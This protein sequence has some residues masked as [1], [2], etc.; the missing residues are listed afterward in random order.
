MAMMTIMMI[1]LDYG[2]RCQG[3]DWYMMLEEMQM[4]HKVGMGYIG[5]AYKGIN[6]K[7]CPKGPKRGPWCG[8]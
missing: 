4:R 6:S 2:C 7:G 8:P 1:F 5:T 3:K